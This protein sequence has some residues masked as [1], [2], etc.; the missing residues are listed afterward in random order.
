M[1]LNYIIFL[2]LGI[3]ILLL[4]YKPKE[5]K[6]TEKEN[7]SN[8]EEYR[9]KVS[10]NEETKLKKT[11]KPLEIKPKKKNSKILNNETSLVSIDLEINETIPEKLKV[12]NPKFIKNFTNNEYCPYCNTKFM[13]KLFRRFKCPYC[14][15]KVFV[16][17]KKYLNKEDYILSQFQSTYCQIREFKYYDKISQ[18]LLQQLEEK[19]EKDNNFSIKELLLSYYDM[20]KKE[21]LK[22]KAYEDYSWTFY[23]LG[24]IYYNIERYEI[25]LNYYLKNIFF[26]YYNNFDLYIYED[27]VTKSEIK[28]IAPERFKTLNKIIKKLKINSR[29][30]KKLYINEINSLNL[31]K[32]LEFDIEKSWNSIRNQLKF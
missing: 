16:F 15:E 7:S 20:V 32:D 31:N 30:M 17:N 1:S 28:N 11:S 21:Y 14:K 10:V 8:K 19:F 2:L 18:R 22:I 9:E 23:D 29:N 24:K 26:E 25:S 13:K 6:N 12:I 4:F 27:F 5:K 3:I